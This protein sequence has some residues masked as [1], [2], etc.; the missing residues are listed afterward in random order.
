MSNRIATLVRR[1]ISIIIDLHIPADRECQKVIC[2]PLGRNYRVS[3]PL[4]AFRSGKNMKHLGGA[5]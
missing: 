2:E 3:M 4:I 5:A 1:L